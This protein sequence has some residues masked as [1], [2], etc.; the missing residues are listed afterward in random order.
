M[1]SISHA[2]ILTVRGILVKIVAEYVACIFGDLFCGEEEAGI[3]EGPGK[4][5]KSVSF[6]G[7][8][9]LLCRSGGG[10]EKISLQ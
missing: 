6:Y 2:G 1:V 4:P 5:P 9:F 7:G 8:L 10:R 3:V